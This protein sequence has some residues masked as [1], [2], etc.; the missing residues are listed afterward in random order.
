MDMR[1]AL[2]GLLV[3]LSSV[4]ELG[5][6]VS[7]SPRRLSEATI[8]YSVSI[9]TSNTEPRAADLMDG[10]VNLVYLKGNLSRS[11][12]KSAL[13]HQ[14]TVVDSKTGEATVIK[15][16]GEQ[17]YLIRMT[18]EE[19][20]TSNKTYDSV[21]YQFT[22]IS[23]QIAG[24]TCEQAIGT[25]KDGNTYTVFFT[26]ALLPINHEF[27]Y[28]NRNLPGLALE[29]QA[30]LGKGELTYTATSINFDP[31]PHQQ[32]ELPTSGYRVMTYEESK[33][34]RKQ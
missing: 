31:V 17:R 2:I 27:Q 28:L 23:K 32:F 26:R 3:V 34:G 12:L 18:P 4:F 11:D 14:S 9:R 13:G 5:A 16:Y 15:E 25:W 8:T 24:Y 7:T 21:R 22:G 10:A 19:W 30:K 6:Q 20:K 1:F 33:G 29:Y